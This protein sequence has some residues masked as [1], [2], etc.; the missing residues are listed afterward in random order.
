MALST[1]FYQNLSKPKI[2]PLAYKLINLEPNVVIVF[3]ANAL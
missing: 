3:A 1:K 2:Q